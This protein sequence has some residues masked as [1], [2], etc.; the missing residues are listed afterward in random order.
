MAFLAGQR[1]SA[2]DLNDAST[3]DAWTAYTPTW[4]ASGTDPTIGNGTLT[5]AYFRSGNLVIYKIEINTGSTTT[6]GTGSAYTFSLPF[7][8]LGSIPALGQMALL[9]SSAS[10]RYARTMYA[11]GS[12]NAIAISEGGSLVGPTSPFTFASGDFIAISG[13]YETS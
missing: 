11:F 10:A 13:F 7:A 1:L 12:P 2:D 9:D 4:A 8:F 3:R 5:G 6:Y